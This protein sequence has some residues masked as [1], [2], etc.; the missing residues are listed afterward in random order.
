MFQF[1]EEDVEVEEVEENEEENE[2][3]EEESDMKY[4][5]FRVNLYTIDMNYSLKLEMSGY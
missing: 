1:D 3:N 4:I 5:K 2:E